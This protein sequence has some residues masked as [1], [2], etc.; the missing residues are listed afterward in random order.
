MKTDEFLA[1]WV[2]PYYL[3]MLHRNYHSLPEGIEKISFND[4]VKNGL[5]LISGIESYR[6]GMMSNSK[7]SYS[8]LP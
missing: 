8:I 1:Q 6:W 2:R 3:Q 5:E 7:L 4:K